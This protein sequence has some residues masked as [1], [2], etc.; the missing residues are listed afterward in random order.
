MKV[1]RVSVR[2]T[3][4][5]R[6]QML[7]PH[8]TLAD[9]VF[10]GDDDELTFHL[11]AFIDG[12]LVSVASF[13]FENKDIFEAAHPYQY[14]LRGMATLPEFQGQG[15]SS[16]LL[17]TAFPLIKQNQCTLLWCNARV[18]AEG[19]YQ[20]VGFKGQGDVFPI[21]TIGDHRLMSIEIR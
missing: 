13:Y 16:A 15:L 9:C 21:P 3:Y 17:K 14:R 18:S 2:D 12:K 6:H 5:L 4:P 20:K 1:L 7:R 8:G 19:F 11:G 10:K